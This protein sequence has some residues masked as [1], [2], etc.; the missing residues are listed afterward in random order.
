MPPFAVSQDPSISPIGTSP[1]CTPQ[2]PFPNLRYAYMP[3]SNPEARLLLL[4]LLRSDD[5][6]IEAREVLVD[7]VLAVVCGFLW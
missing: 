7:L 2:T 1:F 6:G 3:K 5:L 4:P